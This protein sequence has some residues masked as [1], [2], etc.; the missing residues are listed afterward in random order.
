[1][2]LSV[3]P[4]SGGDLFARRN[5]NNTKHFFSLRLKTF[6]KVPLAHIKTSLTVRDK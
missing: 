6:C 3:S 1:M 2:L 5:N 4:A